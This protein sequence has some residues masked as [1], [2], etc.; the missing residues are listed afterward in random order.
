MPLFPHRDSRLR[1]FRPWRLHLL[2]AATVITLT[3]S[4][5]AQTPGID[6][7]VAETGQPDGGKP[8]TISYMVTNLTGTTLTLSDEVEVA[9][10]FR[11]VFDA[12]P[13]AMRPGEQVARLVTVLPSRLVPGGTHQVAFRVRTSAGALSGTV[14]ARIVMPENIDFTVEEVTS[15]TLVRSGETY[16]ARFRLSNL[17]N[18]IVRLTLTGTASHG[19]PAEPDADSVLLTPGARREVEV[20]VPVPKDWDRGSEITVNLVAALDQNGTRM[21]QSSNVEAAVLFRQRGA[22]EHH[23]LPLSA[24]FTAGQVSTP[25]GGA[26]AYVSARAQASG[27]IREGRPTRV[28]FQ[29]QTPSQTVRQPAFSQRDQYVFDIEAPRF[30]LQG[31]DVSVTTSGL[32]GGSAYGVGGAGALTLRFF[33]ADVY[34]AENRFSFL[35]QTETGASAR[36]MAERL[37]SAGVR[38]TRRDDAFSPGTSVILEGSIGPPGLSVEGEYG[39]GRVSGEGA[40]TGYEIR[41]NLNSS[42]VRLRG[43]VSHADERFPSNR[44][45]RSARNATLWATLAPSWQVNGSYFFSE[46]GAESGLGSFQIPSLA[47]HTG[48]VG[49]AYSGFTHLQLR[50]GYE[51]QGRTS[52]GGALHTGWQHLVFAEVATRFGNLQMLTRPSAG[53]ALGPG[54]QQEPVFGGTLAV[55]LAV[56]QER[57]RLNAALRHFEGPFGGYFTEGPARYSGASLGARFRLGSATSIEA[58]LNSNYQQRGN[59]RSS[60]YFVQ[61]GASHRLPWG[62]SAT[63]GGVFSG[64][65]GVAGRGRNLYEV[66]FSYTIPLNVPVHRSRNSGLVSGRLIDGATGRGL[67]DAA[68]FLGP[69]GT[70]TNADGRFHVPRVP[71]GTQEFR[72]EAAGA[73]P[74][75]LESPIE[76]EVRGAR[77]AQAN[78]VAVAAAGVSGVLEIAAGEDSVTSHPGPGIPVRV[79]GSGVERVTLSDNMGRFKLQDLPGGVYVVTVEVPSND[80]LVMENGREVRLAPGRVTM[81]SF[82]LKERRSMIQFQPIESPP[83]AE[84]PSSSARQTPVAPRTRGQLRPQQEAHFINHLVRPGDTLRNLSRMYFDGNPAFWKEIYEANRRAISNP[85]ILVVGITLRIPLQGK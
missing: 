61:G 37:G 47:S 78:L 38:V 49:L 31:G 85:D 22:L 56:W 15:A 57:V 81:V 70:L 69:H 46:F 2:L 51:M 62:H 80:L 83:K 65:W 72:V 13:Y 71:P 79:I 54:G 52:S 64:G 24:T 7:S 21:K 60:I 66:A 14:A 67:P 75:V 55:N 4:V 16:R 1:W 18:T 82:T 76:L 19:L 44:S 41:A 34:H 26:E 23:V 58:R 42:S 36:I 32:A 8:I 5:S 29:I 30:R 25:T 50:G 39:I 9:A 63:I 68:V 12:T 11:A 84:T 74:Y 27:P 6:V 3:T 53:L 33:Q 45:N 10:S 20:S 43:G 17:G 40:P 73:Q 59:Y 48:E 28:R 35:R 77:R